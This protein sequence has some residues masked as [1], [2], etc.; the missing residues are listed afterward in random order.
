MSRLSTEKIA[1]EVAE[2]GFKLIDDSDYKNLNSYI[3]VQ[4]SHGHKFQTTL[5]A[6]RR[7]SFECPL[8]TNTDFVNPKVPP[9]KGK[10]RLIA[11][12]QATEHFGLSIFDDD[13]LSFYQLYTFTGEMVVRL[14]KIAKFIREFVIHQ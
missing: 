6:V 1:A 10:F 8:C 12:D 14:T 2:K 3:T 4:C 5:D 13:K 9:A 11:F 7:V